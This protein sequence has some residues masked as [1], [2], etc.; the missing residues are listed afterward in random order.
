YPYAHAERLAQRPV[1][2]AAADVV[3]VLAAQ[4]LRDAAS[5]FHHLDP[6]LDLAARVGEHFA[7]LMRDRGGEG[8]LIPLDQ[9]FELEQHAR[10]LRRRRFA[11]GR[12]CGLRGS[13]CAA[14][15]RAVRQRDVRDRTAGGRVEHRRAA[16]AAV[17]GS[18]RD[19]VTDQNG[20][21]GR[22]PLVRGGTR[23]LRVEGHAPILLHEPSRAACVARSRSTV[24][25]PAWGY[26]KRAA[27]F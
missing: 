1:I 20:S 26:A 27:A 21:G 10:A 12:P 23:S 17:F 4:A 3:A 16:R 19:P 22:V 7:V 11:P 18:A 2:D 15:L 25:T 8:R 6:A 14:D 13:D 9:I 5:E 24:G